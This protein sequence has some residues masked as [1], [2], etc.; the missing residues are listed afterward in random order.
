MKTFGINVHATYGYDLNGNLTTRNLIN[1]TNSSYSYDALDR[2]TSITH[3]FSGGTQGG[4]VRR[5]NYGYDNVGN[6]KWTKRDQANGDVFA[7][8]HN[9]QVTAVRLNIA[10]PDT[11]S[12]GAQ[13]IIYDA[14]GNRTSFAPYGTTD[15]YTINDLNQYTRRNATNAVYHG[16]GT[17][18]TGVDGSTYQYDAQN[19]LLTASKSGVTETFKY[20]GLNRQVSRTVGG[21]TTYNVWDGWDLIEEYQAGGTI[22]GQYT[23]G[24]EGLVFSGSIQRSPYWVYHYQDGSGSTSHIADSAGALLEWYRY[25]LQGTPFFYNAMGN[26]L[27]A[28]SYSVRHLFT[29]QQWYSE[30]GLYDLRNRFYSPD[31]GRFLQ[32]DPIG[33]AGDATNLYRYCGNNPVRWRDPSGLQFII[34]DPNR[35]RGM[36]A[37]QMVSYVGASPIVDP[38]LEAQANILVAQQQLQAFEFYAKLTLTLF[39][40]AADYFFMEK[41]FIF[42]YLG[43]DPNAPPDFDPQASNNGFSAGGLGF[44]GGLTGFGISGGNSLW[45]GILNLLSSGSVDTGPPDNDPNRVVVFG[46][47]TGDLPPGA[48]QYDEFGN[49]FHTDSHG[50][51]YNGPG[52]GWR[53]REFR[54]S[55]GTSLG[56]VGLTVTGGD[57][58][59]INPGWAAFPGGVASSNWSGRAGGGPPVPFELR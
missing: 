7:Y 13:T 33:F 39:D 4:T 49:P 43:P 23:Y 22:V 28:S 40:M 29:S 30:L 41:N 6:R 25:D 57:W 19:R 18:V 3:T 36:T 12:V 44:A 54:S 50:N 32:P 58:Q 38:V 47:P 31:I 1:S 55:N 52:W 46:T 37:V 20:D 35:I 9:D 2:V 14:N 59:T 21:V 48:T 16:N 8:D 15:T 27:S 24:P 51:I 45:S 42:D 56:S 11:A 26:Q 5:F 53:A 10:N 17:L 34:P